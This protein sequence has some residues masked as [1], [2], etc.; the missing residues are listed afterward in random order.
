MAVLVCK[1]QKRFDV[2][3]RVG[4]LPVAYYSYFL[5]QLRGSL[6]RNPLTKELYLFDHD[7]ALYALVS[8]Q[9]FLSATKAFRKSSECSSTI[10]EYTKMS[11]KNTR[12]KNIKVSGQDIIEDVH[13]L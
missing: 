3:Q 6:W 7:T 11:S 12:M 10:R 1:P 13:E 8:K 9:C 4:S 5:L 2:L